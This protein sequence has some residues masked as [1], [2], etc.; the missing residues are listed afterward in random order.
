MA[1]LR[2]NAEATPLGAML[3]SPLPDVY[4]PGLYGRAWVTGRQL[5]GAVGW[6]RL[7]LLADCFDAD[8]KPDV[9]GWI[10]TFPDEEQLKLEAILGTP[11]PAWV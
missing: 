11:L 2:E 1:G 7:K 5:T 4:L 9:V 8:G 6:V 3:V 10:R